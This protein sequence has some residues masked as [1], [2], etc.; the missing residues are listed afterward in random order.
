MRLGFSR[1][2]AAISVT[3]RGDGV[4]LYMF[5]QD[6][7]RGLVTLLVRGWRQRRGKDTS[8]DDRKGFGFLHR[9]DAACQP[10]HAKC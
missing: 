10:H 4:K 2:V 1:G 7:G 9:R 3:V 8:S 5:K 6:R